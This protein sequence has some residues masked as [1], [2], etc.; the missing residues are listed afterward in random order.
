MGGPGVAGQN[1]G[2]NAH[3]GDL[4]FKLRSGTIALIFADHALLL[5]YEG[6]QPSGGC[7]AGWFSISSRFNRAEVRRNLQ[8]EILWEC[9]EVKLW[10]GIEENH[11]CI[12]S[13][14]SKR[15]IQ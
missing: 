7:E 3:N 14:N 1:G 2:L 10:M 11:N 8:L 6:A 12:G 15:L 4:R 13:K 5:L 9:I